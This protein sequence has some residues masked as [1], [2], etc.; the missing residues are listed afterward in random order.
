MIA[1]PSHGWAPMSA[2]EKRRMLAA[3]FDG[4]LR[5]RWSHWC[6][7]LPTERKTGSSTRMW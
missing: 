2:E 4:M 3:I 7:R 5:T 6:Y 1:G